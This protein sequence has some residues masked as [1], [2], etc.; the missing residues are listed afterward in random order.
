MEKVVPLEALVEQR[1]AWSDAGRRVVFTNGAFDLLHVGHVRYLQAARA[2][3]DLLIVGLNDDASVRGYKGPGRPLVPATERA[4]LLAAL[5]CVDYV[6]LFGE[7]TATRLVTA[8]APDVYAKGGD[9]SGGGDSAG[10]PL[11]EAAAAR[12]GG[13]EVVIVPFVPGRSTT[14]LIERIAAVARWTEREAAGRG[15]GEAAD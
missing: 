11:P 9:Y 5:A 3:G 8:L 2:L 15:R 1:A 14:G 6:V 4:E 12:A 7:P 10:K 13:G